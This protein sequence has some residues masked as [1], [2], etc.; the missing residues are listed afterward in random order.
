MERQKKTSYQGGIYPDL[1]DYARRYGR[2]IG[3][4]LVAGVAGSGCIWP[5]HVSGDMALPGETGDTS[6]VDTGAIPGDMRETGELHYVVLPFTG[7]RNLTFEDPM[8]GWIDYRVE[9]T[10]DDDALYAWLLAHPEAALAAIDAA[11]RQHPVTDFDGWAGDD[12]IEAEIAQVLANAMAGV[13]GA[14]TSGFVQ[15]ALLIDAYTDENDIDGDM[16]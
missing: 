11:L 16:G 12:A 1:R 5:W 13:A 9:L 3:I 2:R 14:D 10:V 7:S 6:I 4:T 15:I 8:W